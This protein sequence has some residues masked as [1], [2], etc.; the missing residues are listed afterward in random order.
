MCSC[1]KDTIIISLYNNPKKRVNH[2]FIHC[3]F[4]HSLANHEQGSEE[5]DNVSSNNN[6]FVSICFF[7]YLMSGMFIISQA[8]S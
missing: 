3:A 8:L 4:I 6:D 5:V 1:Q 7:G 2:S